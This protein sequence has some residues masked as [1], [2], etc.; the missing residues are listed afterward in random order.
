MNIPLPML[1]TLQAVVSSGSFT[2]AAALLHLSQPA[3]SKHIHLLEERVGLP[4]VERV[5]KRPMP[6][7]AGD[8]LLLH[9]TRALAE[10][11]LAEEELK[12]MQGTVAGRV[13]LGTES[14]LSAHVLPPLY[15]RVRAGVPGVEVAVAAS[16]SAGL[17]KGLVDGEVDLG[18]ATAPM[19]GPGP[20][21]A[22]CL[23]VA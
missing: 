2:R 12:K 6:T 8:V 22:P 18:V 3:V 10:L 17:R 9:A 11:D 1:R 14:M 13:R 5:G 4:L 19:T 21:A 16:T 7:S 20:A 23:C 15:R